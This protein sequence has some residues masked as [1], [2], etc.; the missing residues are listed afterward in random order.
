MIA[1]ALTIAAAATLTNVYSGPPGSDP[2][3]AP[4]RSVL[5]AWRVTVAP[6]GQPGV[7]RVLIGDPKHPEAATLGDPVFLPAEPGTY[8]FPAPNRAAAV[9]GLE[10]DS[11]GLAIE[12]TSACRTDLG[13]W[14]DPCQLFSVTD[15]TTVTP[16]ARLAIDGVYDTDYDADGV[17]D[18]TEATDF[19]VRAPAVTRLAGGR[20]QAAV[21]VVNIGPRAAV[22]VLYATSTAVMQAPAWDGPCA[23]PQVNLANPIG[24]YVAACA[25]T[26]LAPGASRRLALAVTPL[27][28]GTL[29]FTVGGYGPDP[30]PVGNTAEVAVSP[31][32]VLA[33]TVKGS[34]VRLRAAAAGHV[35][36]TAS[37]VLR[38]G[39]I[40]R[41][42]R[43]VAVQ[44]GVETTV[45][46]RAPRG[47]RQALIVARRGATVVTKRVQIAA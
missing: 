17:P 13:R 35:R 1:A 25:S 26:P 7:V 29:R 30:Q 8:T 24:S 2:A 12:Q 41:R 44:A 15:G 40:V 21:T 4:Y 3:T 34:A 22:P 23:A 32:P 27:A 5:T 18:Q 46:L 45:R 10:Q 39:R 14:G 9:L 28:T 20:L 42:V 38:D 36:L 33:F 47:A 31:L 16:G 37:Y 6:G 19:S 43:S 11:G